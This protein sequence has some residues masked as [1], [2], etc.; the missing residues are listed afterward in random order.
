[1]HVTR[2]WAVRAEVLDAV[3]DRGLRALT[4]EQLLD[5]AEFL[6]RRPDLE[7]RAL[8]SIDEVMDRLTVRLEIQRRWGSGTSPS[9]I[10]TISASQQQWARRLRAAWRS[11]ASSST[12]RR[13]EVDEGVVGEPIGSR[14]ASAKWCR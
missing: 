13:A 5:W 2:R 10:D 12:R 9:L 14:G 8:I 1:M 6:W 7:P 3:C 4:D 11:A